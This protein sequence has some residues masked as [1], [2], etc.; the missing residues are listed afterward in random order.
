MN[1]PFD[2]EENFPSGFDSWD[3]FN[4][5]CDDVEQSAF[6]DMDSEES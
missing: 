3:D 2:T 1:I 6:A 5:Y 4:N